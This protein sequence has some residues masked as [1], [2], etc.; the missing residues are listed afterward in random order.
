M[1]LLQGNPNIR[2]DWKA[3]R[4]RIWLPRS[5]AVSKSEEVD[6]AASQIGSYVGPGDIRYEDVT[7]IG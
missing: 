3:F 6:N 5:W 2:R 4:Y 7:V 1:N